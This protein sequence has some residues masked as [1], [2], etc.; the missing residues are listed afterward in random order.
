MKEPLKLSF[1]IIGALLF[2]VGLLLIFSGSIVSLY[3]IIAGIGFFIAGIILEFIAKIRAK[4]EE[5]AIDRKAR[6]SLEY[7]LQFMIA[8]IVFIILAAI[9]LPGFY[10]TR[11]LWIFIL[12]GLVGIILFVIGIIRIIISI[13]KGEEKRWKQFFGWVSYILGVIFV[14]SATLPPQ[15]SSFVILII[16]IV[17]AIVG[18]VLIFLHIKECGLSGIKRLR[19]ILN[20]L[21]TILLT[22]GIIGIGLIGYNPSLQKCFFLS[23]CAAVLLYIASLVLKVFVKK[24]QR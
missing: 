13:V 3:L 17:L 16:G 15:K 4:K 6:S 11:G 9:G 2:V 7:N 18:F 12:L 19:Q 5:K 20:N 21:G 8:G 10:R 23:V 22:L 14:G 24:E 1:I